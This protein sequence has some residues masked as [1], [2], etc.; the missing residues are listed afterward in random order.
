MASI[1]CS[2]GLS[3]RLK[4]VAIFQVKFAYIHVIGRDWNFASLL[5][6]N[7]SSSGQTLRSH[8]QRFQSQRL[9]R[10]TRGLAACLQRNDVSKSLCKRVVKRSNTS[11]LAWVMTQVMKS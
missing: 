5:Y 6:L 10:F 11:K 9:F 7:I 3:N 2:I 1:V 8:V 4:L